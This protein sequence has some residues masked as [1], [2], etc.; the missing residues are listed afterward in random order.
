MPLPLTSVDRLIRKAGAYRVSEGAAK[1]LASHLED[2]AV[3]IARE[4]I[5][6]TKHAGRKT[7]R[8]ED[9]KLARTR[10]SVQAK[11][12]GQLSDI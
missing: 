6:L 9:V 3:E 2:V 8:A 12:R 4:A 1:E 11:L 5:T 7:V 10:S